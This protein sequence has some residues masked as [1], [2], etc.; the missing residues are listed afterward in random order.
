V[1]DRHLEDVL[2]VE[3]RDGVRRA[4]LDRSDLD[5][6]LRQGRWEG[7]DV[8]LH[9]RAGDEAAADDL[10]GDP[11]PDPAGELDERPRIS[12]DVVIVPFAEGDE[13]G[14]LVVVDD[15]AERDRAR[16]RLAWQASHDPLT[17][18]VNRAVIT[19]RIDVALAH[20]RRT[21]DWP[22]VLF[23]DLDG[24]KAVNN[25]VGHEAA[26][27]LLMLAAE[28]L[29]QCV[30]NVDTVARLGGDEFVVLC[31]SAGDA[32]V[33]Q[34]LADRLLHSLGEPF[35]LG[36]DHVSL[37]A[38]IGIAHAGPDHPSAEP[39]LHDADLAMV[40]AKQLGRG[41]SAVADQA[42]RDL[43]AER[44]LLERGLRAAIRQQEIG[45]AY[46][47]VRRTATGELVAFE[48]LARW[49]EPMLGDIRPQRFVPV[50]IE[51][52][53]VDALGERMLDLA[54]RDVA[55]WNRERKAV[56]LPPLA[57]HVNITGRELQ[58]PDFLDRARDVMRRHAVLPTWVMLELTESMLLDDPETAI[59]RMR[60]LHRA[61]I[62][63]AIDDF[64]TGNWS[65]SS[66]RRFPVQM[67]KIDREIIAEIAS[68]KQGHA[69][70]KAMIDLA[71]GLGQEVLAEGVETTAE[72]EVLRELGCGLVQ[73][74]RLGMPMPSED[75]LLLATSPT[76]PG[77][78]PA[79]TLGT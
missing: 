25:E 32:D 35:E 7:H 72:L 20:A 75:A 22:S 65:L 50:A 18:V 6:A 41:V 70:V 56:D 16:E 39:L 27:R 48:A 23:V 38:S 58:S 53:L 36:G 10:G 55:T 13:L 29:E 62:R 26:D 57:V 51:A 47:P 76:V 19:E 31:E 66:L 8:V 43:A 4:L 5:D 14:G 54:C 61:G 64:G 73:G 28:R 17:G 68:S 9:P 34:A 37:S 24:F 63:V 78:R 59:D 79:A 40:K 21:G 1:V 49:V 74:Y 12:A 15:N 46:Q 11:R 71:H 44:A 52:G 42:L 2:L 45:V 3:G 30:R 33:V 67:F 69:M 60:A 77:R